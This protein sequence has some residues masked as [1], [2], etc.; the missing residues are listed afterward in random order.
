MLSF[1]EAPDFEAPGD[2]DFDN[3]YLVEV[4]ATDG[5]LSDF[6]TIFVEVT[7]VVGA[8][9]IGTGAKDVID[10]ATTVPG[11]SLP[12]DEDDTINGAGGKDTIRAL[13]GNDTVYGGAG[14][15]KLDGGLG[16]DVM[17]GGSGNDTYTVDNPGD[18]VIENLH[19][20]T[21]RV[22]SSV[23]FVLGENVE[24]LTLTGTD[25]TDGTGNGRA[26]KLTGNAGDN[27][28]SG[29][30]GRD[31]LRGQAGDDTLI[32]G[33]GFD[34]YAGDLGADLFV[35]DAP[36]GTSADKVTDF[37]SAEGDGLAVY[38][39][40]YG[41]AAGVLPDASYFALASRAL[42]DVDHG[43]FLYKAANGTLSWD[44]DGSAATSNTTIATFDT[45][46][47]L[48]VSDFLVL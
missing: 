46:V 8:T 33:D 37:S 21:D 18:R 40:D 17:Y 42:A 10:A 24:D 34:T 11:Q 9:I 16:A 29:E 44:A 32:G 41:L 12:T 27:V 38:G 31:T 19:D 6:Q 15:D 4:A 23:S 25:N 7:D 1:N 14:G 30:R 20:G 22:K 45:A 28:L 35:F 39:A 43:R 48:S 3:S 5:T 47:T 36:S 2:S 13:G 26:N